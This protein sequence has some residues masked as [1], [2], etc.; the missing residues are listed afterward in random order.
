MVQSKTELFDKKLVKDAELFK[1]LAH[2]ARLRILQFL[3]ETPACI[4]G[5]IS[6][7]LPLGRTTVN[8]HL[9]E[10]KKVGLIQGHIL[11]VKTNYCLDP[12]KVKELEKSIAS[13]LESINFENYKCI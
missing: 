11:G 10:L 8:Q 6:D 3:A 2:P 9:K 4:T 12:A 7:E 5:D 13:F 1:A